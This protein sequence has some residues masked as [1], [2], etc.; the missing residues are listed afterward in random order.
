MNL[1]FDLARSI[2]TGVEQRMD[3]ASAQDQPIVFCRDCVHVLRDRP[4]QKAPY[5]RCALAVVLYEPS[6]S[7]IEAEKI[8][9]RISGEI[10]PPPE[11]E[12]N[13]CDN[14]RSERGECGLSGKRF[15]L[16]RSAP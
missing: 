12:F 9:Y 5:W 3:K 14:E 10:S 1:A 6:Q 4:E 15:Q 7:T 8:I 16:K 13:Y 11:P 2:I